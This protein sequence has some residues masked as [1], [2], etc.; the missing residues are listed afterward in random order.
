MLMC[1]LKLVIFCPFILKI[2]S[3]NKILTLIKGCKSVKIWQKMT[4]NNPK[5]DLVT[6]DVQTKFGKILLIRSRDIEL[7]RN[8]KVNQGP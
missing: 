7:K 8:F 1:K 2:L 6:I 5:L 3:G 4:C